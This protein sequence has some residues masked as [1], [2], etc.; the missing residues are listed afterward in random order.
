KGGEWARLYHYVLICTS[1]LLFV[2]FSVL[3]DFRADQYL[4]LI[5]YVPLT[6]HLIRVTK[7]VH[8][9]DYDPE[10]R[11]LALS[12]FLLALLFSLSLISFI[13]DVLVQFFKALFN[14]I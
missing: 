6:L 10:L 12:T 9:R 14:N 4:Y 3:A 2:V 8:P 7:V 11:K 13:Q 5:A 1:M